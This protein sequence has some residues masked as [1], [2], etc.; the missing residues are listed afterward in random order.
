MPKLRFTI[1]LALGSALPGAALAQTTPS[2]PAPSAGG[3]P[4][5]S[6]K[7][8]RTDGVIAP[9]AS[10]DADMTQ[11]PPNVGTMPVIPPQ[12]V[13]PPGETPGGPTPDPK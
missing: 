3:Q 10:G 5:L 6:E 1:L 4:T 8:S 2:T 13:T 7:L 12:A 9:P 11:T